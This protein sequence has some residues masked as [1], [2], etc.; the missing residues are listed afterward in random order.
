M[1]GANGLDNNES[2]VIS[3]ILLIKTSSFNQFIMF[4]EFSVILGINEP[5][6][7]EDLSIDFS[8]E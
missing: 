6:W 4:W 3:Q 7:D 1:K 8:I 2:I 5:L